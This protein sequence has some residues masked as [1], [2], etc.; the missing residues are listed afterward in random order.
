MHSLP[1][2][3]E[4]R[5][6]QLLTRCLCRVDSEPWCICTGEPPHEG[7]ADAAV[8]ETKSKGE[9]GLPHFAPKAKRVIYLFHLVAQAMLIYLIITKPWF[10]AGQSS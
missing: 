4:L 2:D 1:F 9:N 10:F 3:I 8:G 6:A 5:R 7:K